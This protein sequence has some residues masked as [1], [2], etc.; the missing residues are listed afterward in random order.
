MMRSRFFTGKRWRATVI[1]S[2]FEGL[3][4][5]VLTTACAADLR[6][7]DTTKSGR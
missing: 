4:A 1:D 5:V 3:R 6:I 7:G 2:R